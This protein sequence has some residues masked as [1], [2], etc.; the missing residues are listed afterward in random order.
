[1][2]LLLSV[3]ESNVKVQRLNINDAGTDSR[4][5]EKN[6]FLKLKYKAC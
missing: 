5:R 1:M 6:S 4:C 2:Y 3:S